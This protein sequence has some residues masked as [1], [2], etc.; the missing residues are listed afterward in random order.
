MQSVSGVR[1]KRRLRRRLAAGASCRD[2]RRQPSDLPPALGPVATLRRHHPAVHSSGRLQNKR[3]KSSKWRCFMQM[4]HRL[5]SAGTR[6]WCFDP[7]PAPG[8]NCD[9]RQLVCYGIE[10]PARQHAKPSGYGLLPEVA[11]VCVESKVAQR[12]DA[13]EGP[14]RRTW[15]SVHVTKPARSVTAR[16]CSGCRC[17]FSHFHRPITCQQPSNQQRAPKPNGDL[18]KRRRNLSFAAQLQLRLACWWRKK[19][20]EVRRLDGT[21]DA[22]RQYTPARLRAWSRRGPAGGGCRAPPRPPAPG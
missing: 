14:D 4:V 13:G 9:V 15:L 7:L 18:P 17:F 5:G 8:V 3:E 6:L 20:Q 16:R 2:A 10:A 21:S 11:C 12:Q 1:A 19:H 22:R